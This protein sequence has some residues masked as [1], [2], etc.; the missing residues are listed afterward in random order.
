MRLL[1]SGAVAFVHSFDDGAR[2]DAL[3]DVEGYG[4]DFEGGVLGFSCPLQRGVKV[5]VVC[6][7]FFAA[8]AVGFRG[9]EI[10]GR[11]VAAIFVFVVVLFD[12]LFIRLAGSGHYNYLYY[13]GSLIYVFSLIPYL[14][15]LLSSA[16]ICGFYFLR[17]ETI[18]KSIIYLFFLPSSICSSSS[19]INASIGTINPLI[20]ANFENGFLSLIRVVEKSSS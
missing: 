18:D 1:L 20:I 9:Y 8:V 14:K 13:C 2:V 19:Y 4:G 10:D 15:H 7:S 16:F 17:T 12:W 6:V 11:V 5:R 3:M